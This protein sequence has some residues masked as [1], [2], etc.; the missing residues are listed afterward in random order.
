MATKKTDINFEKILV[1]YSF[2]KKIGETLGFDLTETETVIGLGHFITPEF[3]WFDAFFA[4]GAL[5]FFFV[6]RSRSPHEW[7]VWSVLGSALLIYLSYASVQVSVVIN[8]WYGPFYDDIQK[9][10]GGGG[11][12]VASDLY[13]HLLVFCIIVLPYILFVP[14]KIFFT[15]FASKDDSFRSL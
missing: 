5:A 13:G 3:L 4:F 11:E 9:A 14:F 7:Q 15:E 12:V 2:G 10:L 8:A 6:W 1:W